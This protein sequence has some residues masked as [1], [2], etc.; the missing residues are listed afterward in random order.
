MT[1][2]DIMFFGGIILIVVSVLTLLIVMGIYTHKKN[3]LK[4]K[5]YE[6]YGF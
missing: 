5:L 4:R 3:V 2:G 1:F 6:K